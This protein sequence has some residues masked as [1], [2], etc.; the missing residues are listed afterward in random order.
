MWAKTKQVL[1]N[2]FRD[3][4]QNHTMALAAGL[5]YYFVL[6]LFPLLILLAAVVAYLP[7]PDLFNTILGAMSRVVPR[8]SMGLVRSIVSSFI[9]PHR[10]SLLTFGILATMW[11]ASGGFNSLIEALNVA[12]DVPETRPIWKTRLIAIELMFVVGAL[13]VV[14]VGVM[15]VGP[16]FGGW[17]ANKVNLSDQFADMW[18]YL[19]WGVSVGFLV[20]AVELVFFLAPNVLQ[21][22]ISTLPGALIG[23]GTWIGTSYGLGLYFQNYAHL[24]KTYGTLGAAMALMVWLYYSWFAILVGAE[25]NS[26]IIKIRTNRTLQLKHPPPAAVEP[27]PAWEE[28]PAPAAKERPAA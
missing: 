14:G 13:M 21:R 27:K 17:L 24:N 2:A 25:I 12:Y 16:Q 22:F 18:N 19:R 1:R 7:I 6:S 4:M 23:V 11:S 10:G 28:K 9:T 8:D 26:E 3:V 20:L 15:F 5:S